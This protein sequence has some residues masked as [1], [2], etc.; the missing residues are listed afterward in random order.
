MLYN[1]GVH[2]FPIKKPDLVGSGFIKIVNFN[3]PQVAVTP[4]EVPETG[5]NATKVTAS[6]VM[7]FFNEMEI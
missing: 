5:E 2:L 6:L 3:Y 7:F 4:K 1:L